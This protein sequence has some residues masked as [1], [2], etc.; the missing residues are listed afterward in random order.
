MPQFSSALP[1]ENPAMET[2]F[3]DDKLFDGII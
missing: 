3:A 1:V 2:I